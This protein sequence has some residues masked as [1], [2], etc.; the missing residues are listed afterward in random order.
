MSVAFDR[1]ASPWATAEP[2]PVIAVAVAAA[3]E[4]A[5]QRL[6][7]L[8]DAKGMIVTGTCAGFDDPAVDFHAAGP[9]CYVVDATADDGQGERWV[10]RRRN[11][12]P[13]VGIVVVCPERERRQSLRYVVAGSDAL[14]F[15]ED[16]ELGL[17]S[18][19]GCAAAGQL[20]LPRS[21]RSLL[22]PP[23]LSQR[24][25][26]VLELALRGFTNRQIAS[27]LFLAE[28]TVKTH[29]SSAFRRL[30]VRSRRE[31]TALFCA[32]DNQTRRH[33]VP[34]S[35]WAAPRHDM[36]MRRHGRELRMGEAT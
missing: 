11:S 24:E 17:T 35:S 20:S 13:H 1:L 26:E 31:A 15:S 9:D 28:S 2:D 29:M 4:A 18:V 34:A 6:T 22:A 21:M 19:V 12:E 7:R 33:L 36:T 30:G 32:T 8:L 23:A 10:R 25:K 5:A 16:L 14:I 27:A 3:T